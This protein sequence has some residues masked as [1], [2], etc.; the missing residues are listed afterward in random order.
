LH[1]R[2]VFHHEAENAK[3]KIVGIFRKLFHV[4]QFSGGADGSGWRGLG[5]I[6]APDS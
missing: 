3:K 1:A 2:E 4:E 6:S 5:R